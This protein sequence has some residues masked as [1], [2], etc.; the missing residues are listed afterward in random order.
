MSRAS[1][2][3]NIRPLAETS[4]LL[5]LLHYYIISHASV[6]VTTPV[7]YF[8]ISCTASNNVC[9]KRWKDKTSL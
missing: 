4:T 8:Y 6:D 9:I 7:V 3:R 1:T 5:L 2:L